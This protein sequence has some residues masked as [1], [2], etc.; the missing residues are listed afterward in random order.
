MKTCTV[1]I[2][3][4]SPRQ[5]GSNRSFCEFSAIPTSITRHISP[6][7]QRLWQEGNS[8]TVSYQNIC[9]P[10]TDPCLKTHEEAVAK[11]ASHL[12]CI[13]PPPD[14]LQKFLPDCCIIVEGS[15]HRTRDHTGVLL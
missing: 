7:L 15:Q 6:G 2:T 14:M 5:V 13:C 4:I 1:P 8:N 12:T 3:T 9:S 11:V 10:S